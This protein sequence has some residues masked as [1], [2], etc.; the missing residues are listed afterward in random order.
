[1][2]I[3]K[4]ENITSLKAKSNVFNFSCYQQD[5]VYHFVSLFFTKRCD[6][7]FKRREAFQGAH[8]S[9]RPIQILVPAGIRST[10]HISFQEVHNLSASVSIFILFYLY[11]HLLLFCHC[12][13]ALLLYDTC[14]Y[15]KVLESVFTILSFVRFVSVSND[16]SPLAG[17]RPGGNGAL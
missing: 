8:S 13:L 17:G 3:T 10:Y 4:V 9:I 16:P 12:F 6:F 11:R 7:R 1:M 14:L 2:I 15:V 5:N